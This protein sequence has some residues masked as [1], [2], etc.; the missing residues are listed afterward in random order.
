[1]DALDPLAALRDMGETLAPDV[2]DA[3]LAD[4]GRYAQPL[5]E[6]INNDELAFVDSPGKGWMPIH[7]VELLCEMRA[8]DAIEPLLGL[9]QREPDS[10]VDPLEQGRRADAIVRRGRARART[11]VSRRSPR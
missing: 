6:I 4:P 3:L 1:M 5:I 7:A 2:R 8:V 10:G 11:L 9:L